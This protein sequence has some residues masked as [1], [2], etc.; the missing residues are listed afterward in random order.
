M[1]DE[2]LCCPVVVTAADS[3]EE[4]SAHLWW[5]AVV[6]M[7][8]H[9]HRIPLV[10]ETYRSSNQAVGPRPACVLPLCINPPLGV[11]TVYHQGKYTF[12]AMS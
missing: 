2:G 6:L 9:P 4:S 5:A 11:T 10:A 7:A 3:E 8:G 12:C 1:S